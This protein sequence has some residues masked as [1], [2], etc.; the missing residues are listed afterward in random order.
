M[1]KK[2]ANDK[3]KI[4]WYQDLSP[5]DQLAYKY[6][7]P[8]NHVFGET[9]WVLRCQRHAGCPFDNSHSGQCKNGDIQNRINRGPTDNKRYTAAVVKGFNLFR[10]KEPDFRGSEDKGEIEAIYDIEGDSEDAS[11]TPTMSSADYDTL[12]GLLTK[13]IDHPTDG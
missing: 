6:G 12:E 3:L 10:K 11:P 5:A 13:I 4:I 1:S 8:E 2:P 9:G 7:K